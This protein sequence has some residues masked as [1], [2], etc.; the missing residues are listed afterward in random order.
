LE[1]GGRAVRGK[2]AV[3]TFILSSRHSPCLRDTR[4][5]AGSCDWSHRRTSLATRTQSCLLHQLSTRP[6][7]LTTAGDHIQSFGPACKR[8]LE[9]KVYQTTGW[10]RTL[11]ADVPHGSPTGFNN[12]DSM[13]NTPHETKYT[14][15]WTPSYQLKFCYEQL[16]PTSNL[17]WYSFAWDLVES[18]TIWLIAHGCGLFTPMHGNSQ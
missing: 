10:K 11:Q 2:V 14:W 9:A 17:S 3:D 18:P 7:Q 1:A 4:I 6:D 16:L 12:S 15:S 8:S 5:A 13:T